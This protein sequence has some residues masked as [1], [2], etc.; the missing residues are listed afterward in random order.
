MV[1]HTLKIRIAREHQ[2][3]VANAQLR[4]ERIDR[5][6]L[7]TMT[8]AQVAKRCGFDVWCREALQ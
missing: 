1:C 5:A 4:Q 3:A 6:N 7:N 8:A 2:Q